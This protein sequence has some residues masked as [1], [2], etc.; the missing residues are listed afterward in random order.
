[1]FGGIIAMTND[2]ESCKICDSRLVY[3]NSK[4]LKQTNIEYEGQ[5]VPGRK[6]PTLSTPENIIECEVKN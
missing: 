3:V 4:T 2:P 6:F 1:M 5:R